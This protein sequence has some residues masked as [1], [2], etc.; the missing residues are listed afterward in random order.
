VDGF[1]GAI[2]DVAALITPV[3]LYP[4]GHQRPGFGP[5]DRHGLESGRVAP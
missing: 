2:T 1:R 4:H 3:P 5:E